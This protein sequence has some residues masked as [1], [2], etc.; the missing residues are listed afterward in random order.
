MNLDLKVSDVST[1]R[2]IRYNTLKDRVIDLV[3]EKGEDYVGFPGAYFRGDGSPGCLLGELA[4]QDGATWHEFIVHSANGSGVHELVELGY[5]VPADQATKDALIYLQHANDQGLRWFE[6]VRRAF[7]MT[8]EELREEIKVR[9][10]PPVSFDAEGYVA[11]VESFGED[12]VKP[13]LNLPLP[14]HLPVHEHV[15]V[16]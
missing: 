13:V 16:A 5:L 8:A 3:A 11:W 15:L 10:N 14:V 2:T 7:A 6:A 1:R 9:K 12:A 4:A